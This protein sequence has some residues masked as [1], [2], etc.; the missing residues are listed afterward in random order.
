MFHVLEFEIGILVLNTYMYTQI[1]ILHIIVSKRC[2]RSPSWPFP[3]HVMYDLSLYIEY[4]LHM[5]RLE[6]YIG[7]GLLTRIWNCISEKVTT[8]NCHWLKP[9]S[10]MYKSFFNKPSLPF[11]IIAVGHR[12]LC[13]QATHYHVFYTWEH[14]LVETTIIR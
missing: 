9:R 3:K 13:L 6:W 8:P 1:L 2:K 7:V 10:S 4:L 14:H 12:H 11:K 5:H